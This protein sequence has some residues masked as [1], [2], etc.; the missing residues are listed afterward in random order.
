MKRIAAVCLLASFAVATVYGKTVVGSSNASNSAIIREMSVSDIE[1]AFGGSGF[2]GSFSGNGVGFGNVVKSYTGK[3]SVV[4]KECCVYPPIGTNVPSSATFDRFKYGRKGYFAAT[5]I[6][7][8][9]N[10]VDIDLE[11]LVVESITDGSGKDYTKKKNGD[12]NWEAEPFRSSVNREAGFAT[13]M[14]CGGG[15]AWAKSLPKVKGKVTVTV[16]DKMATKDLPGK[17]SSGRIGEGEYSYKVKLASNLM[18]DEKSLEVSPVGSKADCEL[19]VYCGDKKLGSTGSFSMNGKKSYNF[20]KPDG[21]D[22]VIKIQFPEGAK[23]IV[24]PFG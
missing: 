22:I 1:K 5:Y 21:D 14:L 19:E 11:N 17:V 13:F 16:A 10:I 15:N 23:K 7:L 3:P 8:A 4:L 12:A 20:K 24:I 18:S 2:G 6:V 9:Q